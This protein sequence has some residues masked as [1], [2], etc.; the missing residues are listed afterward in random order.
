MKSGI[1]IRVIGKPQE[2]WQ[3]EAIHMYI[4]RY[5][6]FGAINILELPE[7]HSN[8]AKPNIEKTRK[9]EAKNLLQTLPNQAIKI[10]LD[11]QGQ[12]LDTQSLADFIHQNQSS[13]L[14]FFIGGSWG[15]HED[16]INQANLKLSFGR[17]TLPH[18]LARIILLEQL[19]RAQMINH[20][21]K[22]HK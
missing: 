5:Q 15:L 8:S 16:V 12:L 7:G 14:I 10:I 21:R 2:N 4:K 9:T 22:Y 6:S 20:G 18:S 13:P 19:Y 1:Q 3:H 17:I 11:E